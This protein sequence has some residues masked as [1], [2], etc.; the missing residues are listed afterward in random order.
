MTEALNLLTELP[1]VSWLEEI[2]G[3]RSARHPGLSGI[4]PLADGLDAFA[5]RYLLMGKAERTLDVQY[6]IWQNDMSGRLLFCALLE[7]AGRGVKVRLLLDDNNTPGLDDTLARLDRHPNITVKLFNPFSFRTIRALGYLTDF[8]RLNRRMHNKS[9][10]VD[11]VATIVGGRNVGDEYFATGSEPLFADLDVLAI[12]PVVAEVT[13]D[14]ER[15]WQSKPVAPLK[16]VLDESEHQKGL[17]ALPPD[18][19][20]SEAV[21]R[22]L[23]RLDSSHFVSQL[24]QG[25]LRMT[26]PGRVC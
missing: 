24:E 17:V 18:W 19:R 25:T 5:A 1:D 26:W 23:A 4:H 9:F 8:A 10:T 12:G 11:G 21:Q 3:P 14:F 6:Y 2:I 20:D 13:E 22:Y 7:A 15:Y 16:K